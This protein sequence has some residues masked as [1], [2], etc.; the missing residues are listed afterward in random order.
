MF[1]HI[2]NAVLT[3]DT[4]QYD[5]DVMKAIT[6]ELC[7]FCV[8]IKDVAQGGRCELPPSWIFDRVNTQLLDW[9]K[10]PME[11]SVVYKKKVP[12]CGKAKAKVK[13]TKKENPKKT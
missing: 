4:D 8:P 2:V 6:F 5:D 12:P 11:S 9:I 1:H 13:P 3:P 7:K 10:E